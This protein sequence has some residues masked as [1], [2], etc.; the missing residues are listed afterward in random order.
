M[1]YRKSFYWTLFWMTLISLNSVF[2]QEPVSWQELFN[3]KD[4]M[5]WEAVGDFDIEI[6]DGVLTLKDRASMK[7]GWLLTEAE[8]AHFELEAEYYLPPPHNSGV[9][10]RYNDF[11]AGHPAVT[12]YEI[13]LENE[14]Q[15]DYPSGSIYGVAR[16]P[17]LG[18]IDTE[19]WNHLRIRA[20]GDHIQA[21]I[22]D[23]LMMETHERRSF[24]GRIGLQCHGGF[25]KHEVSWRNIRIKP[26]PEPV[27]L[28]PTIEDYLRRT[29]KRKLRPALET[30][31]LEGWRAIG[32]AEW[33]LSDALLTG[34][35]RT[36][37]GALLTPETYRNVYFKCRFRVEEAQAAA[38]V[39]RWD[40]LSSSVGNANSLLISLHSTKDNL[41]KWP[42]GSIMGYGRAPA[43]STDIQGWNMLEVFAFDDQ[44]AVFI[45]G[46]KTAEA[47]VPAAL[48]RAGP[49][50]FWLGA[51]AAGQ[52]L[53][54]KDMMIKDME[55]I[56]FLGY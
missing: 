50:G 22:N 32:P 29:I 16:A 42:A 45:N 51:D 8:Y 10:I 4:L 39:L 40:T 18:H 44:I 3:G 21:W 37:D 34:S 25:R 11:R 47:H 49:L 24:S 55:G 7:G 1:Q 53:Q 5:G 27:Y 56:P 35:T 41:E 20:E 19:G 14:P 17:W 38:I 48:D 43:G 30:A 46:Q 28:G 2:C 23:S 54:V 15:K 52:A 9:A 12:G 36:A 13:N 6:A 33:N 31:S 26:L